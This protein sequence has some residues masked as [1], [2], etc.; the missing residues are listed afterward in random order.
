M[1]A[2]AGRKA[3]QPAWA[4]AVGRFR[5][6]LKLE[7]NLSPHTVENYGRDLAMFFA[8][9]GVDAVEQVATAHVS[10]F[11]QAQA[12]AGYDARTQARRLSALRTFFDFG[13]ERLDLPASPADGIENPRLVKR[14]PQVLSIEEV[15]RLIDA[16]GTDSPLGLRDRAI[17]EVL[18]GTGVRVSELCGLTLLDLDLQRLLIRVTGKGSKERLVPFGIATRDLLTEWLEAGRPPIVVK[19]RQFTDRVFVNAR[20]ARISR[21]GVWKILKKAQVLAGVTK[22]VSPHK[23]RHSFATHLLQHG[24]DLRTVQLLLGHENITTTEIYTHVTRDTL[25][26]V[27]QDFHPRP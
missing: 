17:V 26:R 24:A 25:K 13:V 20:G 10:A 22:E 16:P 14:L 12:E 11:L 15:E 8:H 18:Y 19:A 3:D 4:R 9:A 21:V 6:H 1:P 27:V 7:R 5:Q 2:P 23:L